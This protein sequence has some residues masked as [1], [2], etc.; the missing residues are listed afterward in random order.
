MTG[1]PFGPLLVVLDQELSVHRAMA[2]ALDRQLA[3]ARAR[4]LEDLTAATGELDALGARARNLARERGALVAG[5]PG[6]R[7]ATLAALA[8]LSGAP[9]SELLS[10]REEIHSALDAVAQRVRRLRAL[11]RALGDSYAAALAVL[12]H[13]ASATAGGALVNAEA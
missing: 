6:A 5:L 9:A 1:V 2:G 10:R 13:G 7:P 3:A 11:L 8:R 4:R 12:L